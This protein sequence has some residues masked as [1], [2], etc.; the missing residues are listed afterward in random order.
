MVCADLFLMAGHLQPGISFV[1]LNRGADAGPCISHCGSPGRIA[2]FF[3]L[4]LFEE[5]GWMGYAFDTMENR[6]NALI[7]SIV[8]GLIWA[9]WHLPIYIAGSEST[10]W[11][12]GQLITL[13]VARILIV[14]IF[15][16]TGKASLLPSYFTRSIMYVPWCSLF[17]VHH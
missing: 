1:E 16:N 6:W 11:V 17:M 4:A 12:T 14:W 13:A 2:G 10:L 8:L 3:L 7:A 15:N 5:V 9:A